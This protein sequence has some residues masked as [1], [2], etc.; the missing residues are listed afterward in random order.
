MMKKQ[1]VAYFAG[2]TANF[3]EPEI[4]KAVVRVLR[5]NGITPLLPDQMCCG[6][7]ELLRGDRKLFIKN[8]AFNLQSLSEQDVDIVT[9]C[10]TCALMIRHEYP[11][12]IGTQTAM[13][14]AKRTYDIID[15]LAMREASIPLNADLRPLAL[16][17]AYHAP[18]HLKALGR[19]IIGRRLRL[20][21]KIPGLAVHEISRGC[22]GMGGTFGIKRSH[23][24]QSMAIGQPLFE[25]IRNSGSDVAA[26]E[27]FG[28]KIQIRQRTGMNVMH[29]I[30]I[31][32]QAYGLSPAGKREMV[33]DAP[34]R[35]SPAPYFS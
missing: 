18:C 33:H 13:D 9:A 29:P 28:C 7:P 1:A 27:C 12:L 4:G 17:V 5:K 22:C 35:K 32:E 15:Y 31:L 19:E 8:A 10:S 25:A 30:I 14:I 16:S 34:A 11:S 3:V 2:C 23:Y 26:T 24:E 20:M 21:R 6:A